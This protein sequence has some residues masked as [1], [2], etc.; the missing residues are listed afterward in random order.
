MAKIAGHSSIVMTQ[1]YTHPQ[2]DAIERV[3]SQMAN[4]QEVVTEGGHKENALPDGRLS[5]P[6]NIKK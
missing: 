2:A 3:F 6:A 5:L 1:R 4:R